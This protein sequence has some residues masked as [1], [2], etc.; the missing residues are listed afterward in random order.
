MTTSAERQKRFRQS[1]QEQGLVQVN[2]WVPALRAADFVISAQM[3]RDN[4]NLA[5]G[6]MRDDASG[7]LVKRR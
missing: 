4:P 1:M 3:I 5:L 7:Q 2:V 6:P